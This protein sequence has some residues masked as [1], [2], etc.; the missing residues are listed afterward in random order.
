MAKVKSLHGKG[1]VPQQRQALPEQ[2]PG[3]TWSAW[4][5]GFTTL[6]TWLAKQPQVQ[7]KLHAVPQY[8]QSTAANV[9][10]RKL[11]FWVNEQRRAFSSGACKGDRATSL[12]T[13]PGWS[14]AAADQPWME[15]YNEFKSWW[16]GCSRPFDPL[17]HLRSVASNR[18][19]LKERALLTWVEQQ[20]DAYCARN[21]RQLSPGQ[22][23]LCDE[24]PH[25]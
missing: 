2:L 5:S 6:Q 21:G 17:E 12:L 23:K 18:L 22:K 19:R 11:A 14:W 25:L 15:M 20:H 1:K 16:S 4:H 24:L 8:P 10:E 13:L 9:H 3:W 7:R